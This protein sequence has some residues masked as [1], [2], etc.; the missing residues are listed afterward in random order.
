MI[1]SPF[2]TAAETGHLVLAT[3]HTPDVSQTID[4]IIDV[5]P[6]HQQEQVRIQL[7]QCIQGIMSQQLLPMAG[8]GGRVL[9]AEVLVATPAVR[10][11]IRTKKTEQIMTVLQTSTEGGMM[12]MDKSLKMLYQ[13]GLISYNEAI[14][15]CKFPENFGR[16]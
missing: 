11:I 14:S 1:L 2:L 12:S 8:E 4:R 5:F 7:A 16:I 9:A 10:Q 13:Q 6:S 3:L 15:K